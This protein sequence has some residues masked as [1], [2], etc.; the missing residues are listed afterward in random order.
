MKMQWKEYD[1]E[2][3][4]VLAEA[5][6]LEERWLPDAIRKC[7]KCLVESKAYIHFVSPENPNQLGSD[8]QFEDNII[9]E[10]EKEGDLVLDILTGHRVGGVE[11]LSKL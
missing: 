5:Q 9:L 7:T 4:A 1:P 6:V 3:L 8:W 10:D 11:F 2:W